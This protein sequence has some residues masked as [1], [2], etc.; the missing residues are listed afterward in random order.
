MRKITGF[1][2]PKDLSLVKS[3]LVVLRYKRFTLSLRFGPLESEFDLTTTSASASQAQTDAT[4]AV[5]DF[6][7]S[8]QGSHALKTSQPSV[9]GKPFTTLPKL[10]PPTDTIPFIDSATEDTVD[11]LLQQLPPVL[12]LLSQEINDGSL[13]D[14][15]PEVAEAAM[16]AL[17]LHQKKDILRKVLRSPQFTQS[18]ASLTIA[19]RDGGLP[20]I[21]DALHIPIK[22]GGVIQHGTMPLGGGEAVEA[23]LEGVKASVQTTKKQ[24][25]KEGQMDTS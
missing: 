12:L 1:T 5:Q 2:F 3:A 23:F 15:S 17:S 16:E 18:L 10:L 22:N 14:P 9:Q 11:N 20:S 21:G 7:Q 25:E 13:A 19:L 6:L 8:M 24:R 4:K